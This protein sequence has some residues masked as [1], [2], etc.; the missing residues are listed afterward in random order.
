MPTPGQ[1]ARLELAR[2]FR[3]EGTY[4]TALGFEAKLDPRTRETPALRLLSA[5]LTAT[6]RGPSQITQPLV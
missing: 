6:H 5:K 3:L 4:P 1:L 2:R